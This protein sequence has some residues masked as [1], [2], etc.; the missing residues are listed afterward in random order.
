MQSETTFS[1]Q[2]VYPR[3]LVVYQH[4]SQDES[5][6]VPCSSPHYTCN[7]EGVSVFGHFMDKLKEQEVT[8]DMM[9]SLSN[10]EFFQ[11]GLATVDARHTFGN[12]INKESAEVQGKTGQAQ[13]HRNA[14]QVP[15]EENLEQVQE[16]HKL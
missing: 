11:L 2:S 8:V 9:S 3:L 15:E 10:V 16:D 14:G 4:G 7:Q 12:D 1:F 5:T 13:E 6:P